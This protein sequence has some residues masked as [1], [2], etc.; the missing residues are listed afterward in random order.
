[1][2]REIRTLLA[3]V[4]ATGC[5]ATTMNPSNDA[6]MDTSADDAP[7][8]D[9]PTADAPTAD[10]LP[11]AFDPYPALAAWPDPVTDRLCDE[12]ANPVDAADTTFVHCRTEGDD[13]TTTT[14]PPKDR[15]VVLAFNME[16]GIHLDDQIR[17]LTDGTSAPASDV[18]LLSELDR[19]CPRSGYRNV[20]EDLARALGLHVVFATE[21]VELE[22]DPSDATRWRAVCEHGNALLS[23][24]PI[25]NVR[26]V[27]HATQRSWYTPPGAPADEPRL[28]GRIA[29]HADIQV[30]DRY[31]H[32]A[33]LHLE[34]SGDMSIRTAQA[35][36][37]AEEGLAQPWPVVM[38]GD[39]NA[40]LYFVDVQ[41]G[42]PTDPTVMELTNRG[43]VDA[44]GALP[45]EQRITDPDMSFILDLILGR[46][47]DFLAP[48]VGDG[49]TWD[50]LSDHRPVWATVAPRWTP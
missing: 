46:N 18:L 48:G 16:R 7:T 13:F 12:A 11:F 32:V 4:L 47:A 49:P 44:H 27:R 17:Q 26:A 33:A 24:Y 2:R 43:Y 28:G 29:I 42:V 19:G 37:A 23:R 15:L 14:A 1:M 31:L 25:G 22:P 30:G 6:G 3:A 38:G 21:F 40:G 10:A 20:A 34:S 8:S 41:E 45:Y 36:E 50:G 39:L 35:A 9:A 5:T